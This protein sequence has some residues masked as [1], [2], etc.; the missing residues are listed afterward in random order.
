MHLL[1]ATQEKVASL[2]RSH[3]ELESSSSRIHAE[4]QRL[5]DALDTLTRDHDDHIRACNARDAS[6]TAE[7]RGL[8][9]QITELESEMNDNHTKRMELQ[10]SVS[11]KEDQV[12]KLQLLVQRFKEKVSALT[13]SEDTMTKQVML[14][15][16]EKTALE[17]SVPDHQAKIA[18]LSRAQVELNDAVQ[19]LQTQNAQLTSDLDA[20]KAQKAQWVATDAAFSADKAAL[21]AKVA[22]LE[23]QLEASAASREQLD[24]TKEAQDQLTHRLQ[25]E[26][27]TLQDEL[28]RT[29]D[30]RD[31]W[32]NQVPEK[33]HELA[34]LSRSHSDL[35]SSAQSLRRQ[36]D[37]LTAE[38]E[39]LVSELDTRTEELN[40][41]ASRC[42]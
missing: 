12:A 23:A 28:K 21:D 34:S 38:L 37:R 15:A 31:A 32:R 26:L 16:Q 39:R 29:I 8:V 24:A 30:E 9:D 19:A 4:N 42:S 36:N 1:P 35:E 14:L 41:E 10:A 33:D 2:S 18:S 13:K 27:K 40:D 17:M 7:R 25:E 22:D 3:S 6:M 5:Q 20:I 11:Y